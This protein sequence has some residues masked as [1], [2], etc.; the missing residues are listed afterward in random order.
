MNFETIK[1]KIEEGVLFA[2]IDAPP[3]NLLGPELVRDL[4]SL[5]QSAERIRPSA[6]SSS[7]A[8]IP[9]TSFRMST[10]PASANTAED[11]TA[12]RYGWVNRSLPASELACVEACTSHRTLPRRMRCS[13]QGPVNAVTLASV[14]EFRHVSDLIGERVRDETARL[15]MRKA[16]EQGFPTREAELALATLLA[17][18]NRCAW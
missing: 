7:A 11:Y 15:Q 10:L 13:D 3:M 6:W 2:D 17:S 4:V 14:D 18:R 8:R 12:E 16:F 5:I 1:T 9:N